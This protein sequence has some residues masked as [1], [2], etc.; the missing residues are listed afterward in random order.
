MLGNVWEACWDARADDYYNKSPVDDPRGPSE[1]SERMIRG[2][3]WGSSSDYIGSPLRF[4]NG[5]RYRDERNG[6]RLARG[7]SAP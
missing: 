6:F 1:G 4:A 3:Y 5:P 7:R 2:G